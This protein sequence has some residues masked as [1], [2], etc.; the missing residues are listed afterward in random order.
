MPG[1]LN[2]PD[3]AYALRSLLE[4]IP[5]GS[6]TTYGDLARAL[7]DVRAARWIGEYL[8][9]HPHDDA[10]PCHRVVRANGDVGLYVTGDPADKIERLQSEWIP[11]RDGRAD[12]ARRIPFEQFTGD[13]PL[14]RLQQFLDDVANRVQERPLSAAPRW[15]CGLDVAYRADGT[16]IGAAVL[17]DAE[18]LETI[19]ESTWKAPASFPYIPGYLTFR[20]LPVLLELWKAVQRDAPFRADAGATVCLV[21]GN[22]RLHPRRGGIAC[23]F[24][25]L[26]G[27][28]TVGVTKSLLCGTIATDLATA[29]GDAVVGDGDNV[30]GTAVWNS[31][32][33]K[34]VYV[35]VGH[36]I[37]LADSVGIVR[38]STTMHR[39]PEPTFRADRLSKLAKG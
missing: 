12:L 9:E 15:L 19:A 35:S 18:S 5:P 26:T 8:V 33:S 39:L 6:V 32:T 25:V 2:I 10:C 21:D 20:E 17:L 38:R 22:G 7:G 16:A 28:P 36:R 23:G 27:V 34:P 14:H 11:V 1:E 24:G 29:D 31:R 30:I 4:Q 3:L 13:A 37:T